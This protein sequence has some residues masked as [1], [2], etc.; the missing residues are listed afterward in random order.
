MG[1]IVSIDSLMKIDRG[2]ATEIPTKEV[3]AKHLS[4]ILGTEVSVKIRALS[5]NT[6]CSLIGVSKGKN[7]DTD[8]TKIYKAQSLVVAEGV[9]EPSLKDKDLQAHFGAASPAELSAILFP[10]GELVGI[11]SEIATLSGYGDDE[12]EDADEEV[13]N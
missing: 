8:M 11:F 13:K 3:Q 5:G 9:V 2:L 10:G 7:G 6:Y 4:R 12:D 1:K